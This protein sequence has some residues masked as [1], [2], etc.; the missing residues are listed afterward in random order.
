MPGDDTPPGVVQGN[1][2]AAHILSLKG[3][4]EQLVGI[5]GSHF[6]P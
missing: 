3:K 6:N 2:T 5:V 4:V 1:E